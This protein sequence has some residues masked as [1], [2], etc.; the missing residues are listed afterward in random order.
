MNVTP[1][2]AG[3]TPMGRVVDLAQI[4]GMY[5]GPGSVTVQVSDPL[6]PW[7]EGA[8]R[9]ETVDGRLQVHPVQG[10]GAAQA[11]D[12]A[13]SI[14]GVSALVYGAHDPAD[15]CLRGWGALSPQVV[16]VMRE[17]FPHKLPYLHEVF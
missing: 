7:N 11:A 13:L 17:M 9:L 14:Q 5:T 15:F 12:C 8:W 10:A 2:T 3:F 1:E 4:G 16:A 6:C